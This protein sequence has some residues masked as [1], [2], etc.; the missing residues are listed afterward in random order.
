METP[1]CQNSDAQAWWEVL[2]MKCSVFLQI[3]ILPA[4]CLTHVLSAFQFSPAIWG[5]PVPPKCHEC[6]IQQQWDPAPGPEASPAA[7]ALWHPLPSACVPVWQSGLLQLLH[8]EKLLFCW[9]SWPGTCLLS[10]ASHIQALLSD[11]SFWTGLYFS[12]AMSGR[13]SWRE[14]VSVW[15]HSSLIV[16]F[17]I[18][19]AFG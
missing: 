9:R 10:P 3:L 16:S 14:T 13:N 8:H 2:V 5:Q 1:F 12:L 11:C 7:C 19:V 6:A 15:R 18:R 4:S 17:F